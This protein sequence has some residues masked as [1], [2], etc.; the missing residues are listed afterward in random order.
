MYVH[1]IIGCHMGLLY[2]GYVYKC[3][4]FYKNR[5]LDK[6]MSISKYNSLKEE[7]YLANMEIPKHGLAIYTFGNVSAFD[8]A[9]GVFAIKPSGVPYEDL[10]VED[11]VIVD[12]D[13]KKVEG[14]MNPSSD[15]MTHAV[16]YKNFEGLGGVVH[17]HSP[18]AFG[19]FLPHVKGP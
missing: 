14:L 5:G 13:G 15:T 12:L 17:T 10:K 9:A 7:A 8:S 18:Y 19:A 6:N 2:S 1:A 4:N 3:A 11:M 16:L